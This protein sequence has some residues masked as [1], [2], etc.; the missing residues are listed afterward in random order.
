MPLFCM[1]VS[2]RPVF[3]IRVVFLVFVDYC[4]L[5]FSVSAPFRRCHFSTELDTMAA[6][7]PMHPYLPCFVRPEPAPH[8]REL[9]D[10]AHV[11]CPPRNQ[12]RRQARPQTALLSVGGSGGPVGPKTH[13]EGRQRPPPA[14]H[15]G[16]SARK[17]LGYH[18]LADASG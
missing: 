13:G 8:S 16:A 2:H 6:Y 11:P 12:R 7:T 15:G 5:Q 18:P 1:C 14:Q 3:D 4:W 10:G 9:R 17:P